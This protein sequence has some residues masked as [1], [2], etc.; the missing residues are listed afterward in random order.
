MTPKLPV[1]AASVGIATALAFP[2][3]AAA[4]PSCGYV[5]TE[6][7][8]GTVTEVAGYVGQFQFPLTLTNIRTDESCTTQDR[9][10]VVLVG[11]DDPT[12]GPAYQ[13]WHVPGDPQEITLPPGGSASSVLTF[14]SGDP[15]G[16]WVPTTIIATLPGSSSYQGVP[17][18]SSSS[19]L[20]QDAATTHGTYV[21][22]LQLT[23]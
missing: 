14:L 13:L 12:L 9:L 11:P 3:T 16:H 4:L 22:P 18:P 8:A 5:G 2:A 1:C 23:P 10:D 6:L 19:V 15:D 20:R 7:S 21:G 17:W